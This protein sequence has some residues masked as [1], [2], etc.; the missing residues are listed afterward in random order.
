MDENG[1]CNKRLVYQNPMDEAINC[2]SKCDKRRKL[3]IACDDGSVLQYDLSSSMTRV[4]V[5]PS[6]ACKLCDEQKASDHET[7]TVHET[8]RCGACL[9][10]AACSEFVVAGYSS[11]HIKLVQTADTQ[12]SWSIKQIA[13]HRRAVTSVAIL[14]T[15]GLFATASEDGYFHV[16]RF[17]NNHSAEVVR[18]GYFENSMLLGVKFLASPH[19]SSYDE[20]CQDQMLAITAYD[21]NQVMFI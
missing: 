17:T 9:C 10:L 14:E 19:D 3:Y 18:S 12:Q 16:I 1:L 13:L 5:E 8:N 11:G 21:R 4:V 2:F 20:K 15:M 7:A 6:N